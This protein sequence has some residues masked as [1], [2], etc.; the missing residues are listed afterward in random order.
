MTRHTFKSV[1]MGSAM[2]L[3]LL[4]MLHRQLTSVDAVGFIALGVFVGV[5]VLAAPLALALPAVGSHA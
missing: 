3:M 5:H 1:F 2:C 4:G